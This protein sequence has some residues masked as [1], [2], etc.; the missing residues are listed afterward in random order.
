MRVENMHRESR[1][2]KRPPE[3]LSK[4]TITKQPVK[5]EA[6][7]KKRKHG[8]GRKRLDLTGQKFGKLKAIRSLDKDKRGDIRWECQC[9]CGA[10][11][12]VTVG[13][14]N[15]KRTTSCGC[16]RRRG[17]KKKEIS[18]IIADGKINFCITATQRNRINRLVQ[19]SGKKK[20]KILRDLIDIA[21]D[22]L[23]A[24]AG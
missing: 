17:R 9:D 4:P 12:Q 7:E 20:S 16:A 8:G 6:G 22:T 15:G 19:L 5:S 2:A 18:R 13:N 10:Y 21:L 14:L 3:P 24:E 11:T 23:T 1:P